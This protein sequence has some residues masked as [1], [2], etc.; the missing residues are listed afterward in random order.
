[1]KS[2][3]SCIEAELLECR[4]ATWT[5]TP[6]RYYL[7]LG[8]MPSP[9]SLAYLLLFAE[10]RLTVDPVHAQCSCIVFRNSPRAALRASIL[11][12][13]S[14]PNVCHVACPCTQRRLKDYG[15]PMGGKETLTQGLL[16][17]GFPKPFQKSGMCY[18]C[19]LPRLSMIGNAPLVKS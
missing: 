1:M 7:R 14:L 4:V 19:S 5:H 16:P 9:S 13:F 17:L 10:I 12:T 3:R 18:R 2:S 15:G 8:H 11:S 6:T